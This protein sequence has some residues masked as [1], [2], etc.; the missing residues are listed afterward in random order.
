ME[1][2]RSK[3]QII[4]KNLEECSR[5]RGASRTKIVYG[6]GM[7]FSTIKPYM[8]MLLKNGLLETIDGEIT[9]Y[10]LTSKG[11][12]AMGHLHAIEGLIPELKATSS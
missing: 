7:N 12:E 11:G 3:D 1:P 9:L 8:A 10:K 5:G 6:A 4:L 2:K